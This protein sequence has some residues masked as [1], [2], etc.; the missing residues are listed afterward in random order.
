MVRSRQKGVKTASFLAVGTALTILLGACD[1]PAPSPAAALRDSFELVLETRPEQA[2]AYH[3]PTQTAYNL[4]K[5]G[6]TALKRPVSPFVALSDDYVVERRTVISNGQDR[7]DTT[8]SFFID[9]AG[10][11]MKTGCATTLKSVSTTEI[12]HQGQVQKTSVTPDGEFHAAAPAAVKSGSGYGTA[13]IADTSDYT[14]IKTH[15]GHALRCLPPGHASLGKKVL[16]ESCIFDAGE[17]RTL[18]DGTGAA[19]PVYV[20]M[21]APHV[22][23]GPAHTLLTEP[24]VLKTGKPVDATAFKFVPVKP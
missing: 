13:G 2:S 3:Y 15:K 24:R 12:T 10:M 9:M 4:C 7:Y 14:V 23:D 20:R 18:T 21:Q 6:A 17:G 19:I 8:E 5:A 1:K 16:L 11:D 22:A